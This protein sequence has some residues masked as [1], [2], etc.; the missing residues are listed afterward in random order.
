VRE[1]PAEFELVER[2]PQTE[3]AEDERDRDLGWM[4]HDID[5]ANGRASVFFRAR[6][7]GGVIDVAR[8]LAEGS[9]T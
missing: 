1:F 8:C 2:F 7:E 5:Y 4:L 6:M 9:A 3:L